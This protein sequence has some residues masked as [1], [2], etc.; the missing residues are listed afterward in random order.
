MIFEAFLSADLNRAV[1]HSLFDNMNAGN[2]SGAT[3]L[4]LSRFMV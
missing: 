3:T 2:H 4:I 1:S